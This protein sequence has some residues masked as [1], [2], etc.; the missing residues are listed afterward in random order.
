[1]SKRKQKE[2]AHDDG[3]YVVK[4]SR[5]MNIVALIICFL[6]AVIIWL[7]ASNAEL[8]RQEEAQKNLGAASVYVT[9]AAVV[10]SGSDV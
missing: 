9:D 5:K 8:K 1:M 7:N 10:L 6:V 2:L 3:T 4:K